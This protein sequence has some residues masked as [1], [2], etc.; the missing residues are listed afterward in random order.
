[1][2][3][4]SGVFEV[5]MFEAEVDS[6]DHPYAS[7]FREMLESV[8]EEYVSKLLSFEVHEGTVSF[9]FDSDELN[10]E[11]IDLLTERP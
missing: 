7:Q 11:I 10:A 2:K 9:S 4:P 3:E 5:D 8:A 1:M 6:P